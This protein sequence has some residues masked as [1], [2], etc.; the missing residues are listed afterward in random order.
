MNAAEYD[1]YKIAVANAGLIEKSGGHGGADYWFE[2]NEGLFSKIFNEAAANPVTGRD[3]LTALIEPLYR[4]DPY[5]AWVFVGNIIERS[6]QEKRLETLEALDPKFFKDQFDVHALP[7]LL[8]EL[9]RHLGRDDDTYTMFKQW[10]SKHTDDH[11]F[12]HQ[13]FVNKFVT[14]AADHLDFVLDP[15]YNTPEKS[16][17]QNPQKVQA[18][19]FDFIK[20]FDPQGIDRLLQKTIADGPPVAKTKYDTA[21]VMQN[22]TEQWQ[23]YLDRLEK[24]KEDYDAF[25]ADTKPA[26]RS[27]VAKP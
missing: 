21:E 17:Y 22:Q 8:G 27:P 16:S 14:Q 20:T 18:A 2:L 25:Y 1:A 3:K 9:H 15:K 5:P 11:Q 12:P 24:M 13:E 10:F 4:S 6:F 19:I 7:R 23:K 26:P